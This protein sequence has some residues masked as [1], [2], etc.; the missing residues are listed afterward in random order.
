MIE[1]QKHYVKWKK[2]GASGNLLWFVI[3]NSHKGK[4]TETKYSGA[5][6]DCAEAL[7]N[8][9]GGDDRRF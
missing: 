2:L 9:G 3:L 6:I 4:V 1:C 8:L 5:G 7:G